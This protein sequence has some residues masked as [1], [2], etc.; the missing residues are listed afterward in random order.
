MVK[1]NEMQTHL[2]STSPDCLSLFRKLLS[3]TSSNVIS[4]DLETTGLD[5]LT[6]KIT[7]IALAMI[8]AEGVPQVFI[9]DRDFQNSVALLKQVLEAQSV[10]KI[11]HN[12]AL[13]VL[14]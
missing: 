10:L 5:P 1:D 9:I 3:T 6:E 2:L 13:I 11:L 14:L 4:V 8:G 12:D 7:V